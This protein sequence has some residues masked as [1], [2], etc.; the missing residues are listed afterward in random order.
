MSINPL[1]QKLPVSTHH[2]THTQHR[3]PA[4]V[5]AL[6]KAVDAQRTNLAKW[7]IVGPNSADADSSAGKAALAKLPAT[8]RAFFAKQQGALPDNDGSA[9]VLKVP[10]SDVKAGTHGSAYAVRWLSEDESLD[11]LFVYDSAG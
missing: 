7:E 11:R 6:P 8:V 4:W 9:M 3:N 1:G 10:L 2:R 5:K